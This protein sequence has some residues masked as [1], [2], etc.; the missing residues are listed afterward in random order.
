MGEGREARVAENTAVRDRTLAAILGAASQAFTE[1]GASASMADIAEAAGVGRATLY[2]Y[3][4]TRESM[5]AKLFDVAISEAGEKISSLRLEGMEIQVAVEALAAVMLALVDR[6]SLLLQDESH[7]TH[8]HRARDT[9][10]PPL[11]A[12]F[13]D[14]IAA[15]EIREGITASSLG[16][17]FG[18]LLRPASLLMAEKGRSVAEVAH[19]VAVILCQGITSGKVRNSNS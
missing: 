2:R 3:F 17:Y 13:A 19:E 8:K 14:R 10:G 16:F 7:M 1:K 18:G 5:L 4:P 11:E 6:Y 12:F 15:G 9:I